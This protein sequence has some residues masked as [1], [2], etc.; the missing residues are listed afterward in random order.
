LPYVYTFK[1]LTALPYVYK[2][3]PPN[4]CKRE[5]S[6]NNSAV[7]INDYNNNEN[8]SCLC[9]ILSSL[10]ARFITLICVEVSTN[11]D[12]LSSGES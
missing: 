12:F 4:I 8:E 3:T 7:L 10:A 5:T 9:A 6:K 1:Y 11:N 2:C